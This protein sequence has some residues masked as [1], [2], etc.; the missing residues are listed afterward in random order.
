MRRLKPTVLIEALA[1]GIPVVAYD[2]RG[3][4]TIIDQGVNGYRVPLRDVTAFCDAVEKV[5]KDPK[6]AQMKEKRGGYSRSGL[7]FPG[8]SKCLKERSLL[9]HKTHPF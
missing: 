4:N 9:S 5:F 8:M 6:L 2:W 1:V 3:V 7:H